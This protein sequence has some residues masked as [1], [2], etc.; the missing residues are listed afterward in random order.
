M[1][2]IIGIGLGDEEHPKSMAASTVAGN[3]RCYTALCGMR[4]A[5]QGGKPITLLR[6]VSIK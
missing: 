2:R 1:A 4:P 6:L 5:K 3:A